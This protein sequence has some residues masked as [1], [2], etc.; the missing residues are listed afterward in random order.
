VYRPEEI[1]RLGVFDINGT[2]HTGI[3]GIPN[4]IQDG[5]KNLQAK[6]ILSTIITGRE[7]LR[8]Q[9]LLGAH[10]DSIVS[11]GMPV[12]VENGARLVDQGGNNLRFHQLGKATI[13]AT[14]EA[15]EAAE[16]EVNYVGYAPQD[17][18]SKSVLWLPE[19]GSSDE[20]LAANGT[21]HIEIVRGS[22]SHIAMRLG[23]DSACMLRVG[24]SSPE[25]FELLKDTNAVLNES[26]INVLANGVDKAT[27][28]IDI[29]EHVSVPL[30]GILVAGNDH[31]DLPMLNLPVLERIFITSG[32]LEH[33]GLDTPALNLNSPGELGEYLCAI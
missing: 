21:K 17:P 19:H 33:V 24:S 29:A 10:W 16:D 28:V 18:S 8:A 20:Y 2:I 27:G 32:F 26:E 30:S 23:D 15:V 5:F 7:T 4:T 3:D 1:L 11:E 22:L 25:V 9:E 13:D 14:L 12:A 6:S 31:N